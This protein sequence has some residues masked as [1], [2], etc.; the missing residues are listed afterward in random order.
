MLN[1]PAAYEILMHIE[2]ATDLLAFDRA[3]RSGVVEHGLPARDGWRARAA[4]AL[5]SLATRLD[6]ATAE[7]ALRPAHA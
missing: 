3:R 6:R 5:F 2:R 7:R 4:V 1:H